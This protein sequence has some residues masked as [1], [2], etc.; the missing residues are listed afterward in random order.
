MATGA[1][2]PKEM[3]QMAGAFSDV[4]S[5]IYGANAAQAESEELGAAWADTI[6]RGTIALAKRMDLSDAE[7]D[8]IQKVNKLREDGEITAEEAIKRRTALMLKFAK[9]FEGE[10][11][12]AFA[13]PSGRV[14]QMWTQVSNIFEELGAPFVARAPEFAESFAKIAVEIKPIAEDLAPKI[15]A[16]LKEVAVGSQTTKTGSSR[17]LKQL[18][19]RC[20]S[21]TT[22]ESSRSGIS[23]PLTFTRNFGLN[24]GRMRT[25]LGSGSPG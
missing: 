13:T 23:S 4:L 3:G 22:G 12:R 17:P 19:R 6:M 2:A 14:A 5:Y 1:V 7:I 16:W 21:C 20:G 11:T 18:G 8:L 24:S 15:S 25:S 10:T 9:K